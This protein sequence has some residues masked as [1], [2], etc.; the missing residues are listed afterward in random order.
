ME[1]EV[2]Y[3]SSDAETLL[4]YQLNRLRDRGVP[5]QLS[6]SLEKKRDDVLCRAANMQRP[7][8]GQFDLPFLPIIPFSQLPAK[9]QIRIIRFGGPWGSISHRIEG[10]VLED[11]LGEMEACWLVGVNINP[12][13]INEGHLLDSFRLQVSARAELFPACAAI[14]LA[15]HRVITLANPIIA[16]GSSLLWQKE[17]ISP[18]LLDSSNGPEFTGQ[19]EERVRGKITLPSYQMIV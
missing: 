16:G 14:A 10:G 11:S 13:N 5:Q 3:A 19:R 4:T 18:I 6:D 9:D 2:L 17:R 7:A 12:A 15:L 1:F 8:G